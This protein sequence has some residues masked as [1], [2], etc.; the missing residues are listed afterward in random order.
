[1]PS[2]YGGYAM[3]GDDFFYLS[4]MYSDRLLTEFLPKVKNRAYQRY[5]QIQKN[6]LSSN[7]ICGSL[8]M[9]VKYD[10]YFKESR[11]LDEEF[12]FPY[13]SIYADITG[14]KFYLDI[15]DKFKFIKKFKSYNTPISYDDIVKNPDIF[16]SVIHC[17]LGDFAFTKFYIL[18]DKA[19]RVYIG[20]KNST[21]GLSTSALLRLINAGSQ[22]NPTLFCLW[23]DRHTA[24]YGNNYTLASIASTSLH[25][26]MKKITIPKSDKI[27]PIMGSSGNNWSV[28]MTYSGTRYG[29]YSYAETDGSLISETSS[30]LIFD[31]PLEFYNEIA[32]LNTVV[33]CIAVHRT[34]RKA[35]LEYSPNSNSEPWLALGDVNRPVSIANVK[36]YS[37]DKQLKMYKKRI[38]IEVN[39][40]EKE[41]RKK[42]IESKYDESKYYTDTIFPSIYQFSGITDTIRLELIEF[43]PEESNTEFDNNIKALFK[44]PDYDHD[45]KDTEVEASPERYLEYLTWLTNNSSSLAF[46]EDIKEILNYLTGFNPMSIHMDYKEFIGSKLDLR[47][48]KFGKLMQ[49]ISTDPYIYTEYVKFMDKL[50]YNVIRDSGSPKYFKFYTGIVTDDELC[51]T[52]PILMND[53]FL[54][55]NVEDELVTFDEPNSYIKVHCDNPVAYTNVFIGGRLITPTLVKSKLNDIYIFLPCDKVKKYVG[56]AM[57]MIESD[58]NLGMSKYNLITV[59]TYGTINRDASA[60]ESCSVTFDDTTT[61]KQIFTDSNISFR[62]SDLVIYNKTTGEYIPLS[63]F[64]IVSSMDTAK[65]T[66]ED[67]NTTTIVSTKDE[68]I[69][70]ATNLGEYF[71]TQDNVQIILSEDTTD[72]DFPLDDSIPGGKKDNYE[73]YDGKMWDSEDLKF[74]L[75]DPT[76]IGTEIEFVYNPAAYA[77]DIPYNKFKLDSVTNHHYFEIGGFIGKNQMKFFEMYVNGEYVD[78]S[79]YLTLPDSASTSSRIKIDIPSIDDINLWYTQDDI[80][81]IQLRYNPMG[82]NTVDNYDKVS[83]LSKYNSTFNNT[84]GY[85][86]SKGIFKNNIFAT[87]FYRPKTRA[88]FNSDSS[89]LF[90]KSNNVNS[91]LSV[92]YKWHENDTVVDI[93][94]IMNITTL[95]PASKYTPVIKDIKEDNPFFVTNITYPQSIIDK[96]CI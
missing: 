8:E 84:S 85:D 78:P 91:Y 92:P 71:M 66:F 21:D 40:F 17:K 50:N 27:S 52:N 64:D 10:Y 31:I 80:P 3:P 26:G 9:T 1:M 46:G 42:V 30:S 86:F 83:I 75:S 7:E 36:I 73:G 12:G 19:Q 47:K 93:Q 89:R 28:Y 81:T 41:F 55:V 69:Y 67:G 2:N 77:W 23:K 35:I 96:I 65:V 32:S 95:H 68:I 29:T 57:D 61:A 60:R 76:L 33:S 24:M 4:S 79:K 37:Y 90:V 70:L 43:V 44:Y 62:L 82:Y 39:N 94:E 53:E 16:T 59:E 6:I 49:L 87:T 18:K 15:G 14:Q 56:D 34:N 58:P 63:K 45:D 88:Y 54:C 11:E 22:D 51:G 20:I 25:D 38:P 74:I 13:K 72:V 5:M 48:Y